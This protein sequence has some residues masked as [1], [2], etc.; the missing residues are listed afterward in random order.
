MTEN[1]IWPELTLPAAEADAVR[2]EYG[3]ATIILEY[4][5]GG[6]TMLASTMPGKRV[7]SVESD[8]A[9]AIRLQAHIDQVAPPSP[10]TVYHVDIGP[11]GDWGKPL[12]ER[13]WT[14]FSRYP[15]DIWERPFFRHPDLILIDGRFRCACLAVAGML[16]QRPLR[17]LFD[18]YANRPLY[19]A[20]EE[21]FP[22]TDMIGRMAVFDL[23]P[24]QVDRQHLPAIMRLFSHVSYHGRPAPYGSNHVKA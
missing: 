9:W 18:D 7:F 24:G 23:V 8:R 15:L 13:N 19:H 22:R 2:Q 21:M 1:G 4:G 12:D 5:S 6:S 14:R 10:A 20:V 3:K 16:C 17:V 11:T